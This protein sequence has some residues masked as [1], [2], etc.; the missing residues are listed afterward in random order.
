MGS[1]R[2][3]TCGFDQKAAQMTRRWRWPPD[4]WRDLAVRQLRVD[5]KVVEVREDL[6]GGDRA[7]SP[8]RSRAPAA[9]G[10]SCLI[11]LLD[12]RRIAVHFSS[13]ESGSYCVSFFLRP[14]LITSYQR[15]LPRCCRPVIVAHAPM[16]V[17]RLLVVGELH[18][19]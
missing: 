1:S 8:S 6:G 13:S 18:A 14:L 7:G 2:A 10:R 17:I 4:I 3:M 9:S 15:S 12:V 19:S 11:E 5:A 16:S